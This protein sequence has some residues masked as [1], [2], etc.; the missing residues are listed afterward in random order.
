M[1]Q[2]NPVIVEQNIFEEF[3][4]TYIGHDVWIGAKAILKTGV[5]IGNGA[6]V[7]AGAVVTSDVAP[8]SIVGGIPAKLIRYRFE[9]HE[10]AKLQAMNWWDKDLQWLIANKDNFTDIHK[11]LN[12][13]S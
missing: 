1:A 7:A 10:I 8:Y 9:P 11:L 6:I 2:S 5:T 3:P 4:I 13:P 12:K